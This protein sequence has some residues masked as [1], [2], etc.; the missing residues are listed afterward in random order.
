MQEESSA[1]RFRPVSYCIHIFHGQVSNPLFFR[2][3]IPQRSPG[4]W[5]LK[6]NI[7]TQTVKGWYQITQVQTGVVEA[8]TL[9]NDIVHRT[10][11]LGPLFSL[12]FHC[13][14]IQVCRSFGRQYHPLRFEYLSKR[15]QALFQPK[16][17]Q[18]HAIP[19][20]IISIDNT[21]KVSAT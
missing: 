7:F 16:H 17:L 9:K 6:V 11:Y 19:L 3:G 15:Q 20:K 4:A 21:D 13:F 12:R 14:I 2:A 10:Q 1:S 5:C 8:V 18:S